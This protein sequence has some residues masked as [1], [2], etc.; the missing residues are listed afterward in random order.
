MSE[1]EKTFFEMLDRYLKG[2]KSR[3]FPKVS[4]AH[5]VETKE[6]Y[7]PKGKILFEK[8]KKISVDFI[9]I[10]AQGVITKAIDFFDEYDKASHDEPIKQKVFL[11]LGIGYSKV[12]ANEHYDF[13]EILQK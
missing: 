11:H 12:K 2:R 6:F 7:S 10:D 8:I 5:I 1:N 13:S 9:I 3:L 4:L